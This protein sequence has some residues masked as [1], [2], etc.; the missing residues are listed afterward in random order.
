[1]VFTT[2]DSGNILHVRSHVYDI[3]VLCFVAKES[4]LHLSSKIAT[5]V[6]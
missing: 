6:E 5:L 3:A 1:M 4:I 2:F